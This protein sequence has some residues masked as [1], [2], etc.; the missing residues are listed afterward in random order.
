MHIMNLVCGLGSCAVS[1][2]NILGDI[3]LG[4]RVGSSCTANRTLNHLFSG[5]VTTRSK[6]HDWMWS[7]HLIKQGTEDM[8]I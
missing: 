5:F 1:P 2:P 6:I 7:N 8:E 4:Y 3:L